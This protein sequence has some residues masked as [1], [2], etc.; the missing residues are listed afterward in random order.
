V[1]ASCMPFAS[2]DALHSIWIRVHGITQCHDLYS[3]LISTIYLGHPTHD[4]IWLKW[5]VYTCTGRRVHYS[6]KRPFFTRHRYLAVVL[7]TTITDSCSRFI[8]AST[9]VCYRLIH[10][11]VKAVSDENPWTRTS[12][13]PIHELPR[14]FAQDGSAAAM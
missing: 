10:C 7:L 13:L 14:A 3:A 5:G 12:A 11:M 1:T 4:G 9:S 8:I 2:K 6:L